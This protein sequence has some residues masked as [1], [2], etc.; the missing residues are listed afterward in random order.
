LRSLLIGVRH[1]LVNFSKAEPKLFDVLASII[2]SEDAAELLRNRLIAQIRKAL[3]DGSLPSAPDV[4]SDMLADIFLSVLHPVIIASTNEEVLQRRAE[5]LLE[6]I[7]FVVT[8]SRQT[9]GS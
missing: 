8:D 7:S 6:F 2:T 5:S 4:L 3:G 9:A 1:G